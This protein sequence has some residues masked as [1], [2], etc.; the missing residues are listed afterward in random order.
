M[1]TSINE[2]TWGNAFVMGVFGEDAH[3]YGLNPRGGKS[4]FPDNFKRV[5]TGKLF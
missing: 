2:T 4:K 5:A 1:S 3:L